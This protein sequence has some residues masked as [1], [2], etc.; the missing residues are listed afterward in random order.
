MY[1]LCGIEKSYKK[2]GVSRT[3]LK[4]VDLDLPSTGLSLPLLAIPALEN[5]SS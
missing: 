1:K 5:Q 2:K 4:R 3:A